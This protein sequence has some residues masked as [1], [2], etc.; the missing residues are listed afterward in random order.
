VD[1][2]LHAALNNA[3]WAVALA[4][5]AAAGA[6][7]WRRSPALAHALWLLVLLKLVTPSLTRFPLPGGAGPGQ[8]APDPVVPIVADPLSSVPEP[9]SIFP[10]DPVVPESTAEALPRRAEGRSL[11]VPSG[12]PRAAAATATPW[13]WKTITAAGWLAGA[14]AWWSFL[15]LATMRFRRLIASAHAAPPDI[16]ERLASLAGRS[17]LRRVPSAWIVP[18]RV[19]PML[20]V[21]L[22]GRPRLVLPEELWGRL[23]GMQQDAILAHE[24]AH[25]GRRDHWVRRL[26]AAV[27]GLYWWDPVAWWANRE[28]ERAE[29]ECCDAWVVALLPSAAGAYA[30][31]LVATAAYLSGARRALPPGASGVGRLEPIKRRIQ[32][33]LSDGRKI[34]VGRTTPRGLLFLGI[35]SL[36]FLPAAAPGDPPRAPAQESAAPKKPAVDK[37]AERPSPSPAVGEPAIDKPTSKAETPETKPS[38]PD[39]KIRVK[40]S[41]PIRREVTDTILLNGRVE[42]AMSVALRPRVSGL[43]VEVA[44]QP[45][46][47]VR[48]GG[49]LYVIDSRSYKA[50][51]EKAEAEVRVARARLA[52]KVADSQG[53]AAVPEREARARAVQLRLESK[54]EEAS[55][56]AAEKAL[57]IAQLNLA[58]TRLESP[59][60]GTVLGPVV[61]AG[62]VAVADNTNLAT[63]VSTDPMY[64]YFEVPERTVLKLNRLRVEGKIKLEPGKGL[65]VEVGLQD[66]AGFARQGIVS[67]LSGAVDPATGTA[68]WRA[69]IPNPDEL[70]L[71]GMF[72][73][74]RLPIGT[75]HQ[76]LLV[77]ERAL[78]SSGP[79]YVK[80]V[81]DDGVA[82]NRAVRVGYQ[83]DNMWEITEGI[84]ANDWVV[85]GASDQN[86]LLQHERSTV[87]VE[88]VPMP[89]EASNEGRRLQ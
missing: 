54:V 39:R 75:P 28:L 17:G 3:A 13:P 10:V 50:A 38:P 32:M 79:Q 25:L 21:P 19:P 42:S 83:H 37:P 81:S 43:I 74:V 61:Q 72:A 14:A 62:N 82:S 47:N 88:R 68:R 4:L 12:T 85:V 78:F 55:L 45:G 44:C 20:W 35:L 29:E 87:E 26:E 5:A 71:P 80:V 34:P 31:A 11:P 56:Q 16:F 46:Q 76:A 65:S 52:A 27:L 8:A 15:G 40:A 60:D 84:E 77:H 73:K 9:R 63:I 36:P 70:L 57:E 23:D 89:T 22:F 48:K 59:I 86:A 2:L 53:A 18:A 69:K 7:I 41:R 66:E 51:L 30:E 6:R 49:L 67:S 33:I 58:F 64:V 24:L 1:A